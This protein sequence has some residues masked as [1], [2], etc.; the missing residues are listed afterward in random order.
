MIVDDE[1]IFRNNIKMMLD[2]EEH[3][4]SVCGEASG[5][6]EAK[7]LIKKLE[8]DIVITDIC[9]A[10]V[11][12][13]SLISFIYENY[14]N[15][16]VIAISGYDQYDYLRTSMKYGVVDYLLKHQLTKQSLLN[17]LVTAQ[18][19][20]KSEEKKHRDYLLR[21]DHLEKGRGVYRQNFL[22]NLLNSEIKDKQNIKQKLG[23]LNIMLDTSTIKVVVA[24]IDGISS[25]KQKY[26][27]QEW[28]S[29]YEKVVELMDQIVSDR[30]ENVVVA[31]PESRFVILFSMQDTNSSLTCY[32]RVYACIK[33][34]RRML[35][36]LYNLTACYG[37]S[38][39]TCEIS[40]LPDIYRVTSAMLDDKI[41]QDYDII[42][43]EKAIYHYTN[44]KYHISI[45]EEQNIIKLLQ[46]LYETQV[47]R[48]Y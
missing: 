43:R 27:N 32:N 1:M 22:R 19:R 38:E 16:Q 20:A 48:L 47:C 14:P 8:P 36:N 15:I 29:I 28:N 21:L 12:G 13:L 18:R 17:V 3:G 46:G 24:E 4:F 26:T 11:D 6:H 45:Q 40:R 5:G 33:Q 39:S 23:E 10:D 9:M 25:L 34:I 31:L 7:I 2:W 30:G 41:Y 37:I 42:I 44:Q 35:K